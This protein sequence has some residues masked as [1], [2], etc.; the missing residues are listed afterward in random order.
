MSTKYFVLQLVN[1]HKIS[2]E[3]DNFGFY[4]FSKGNHC[5]EY[6]I[7]RHNCRLE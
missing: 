4:I 1:G 3:S 5:L 6:E 2:N 7:L